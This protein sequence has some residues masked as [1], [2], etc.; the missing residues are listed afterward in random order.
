MADDIKTYKAERYNRRTI[1]RI[2]TDV[3]KDNPMKDYSFEDLAALLGIEDSGSK[4]MLQLVVSELESSERITK[5]S[6]GN[7]QAVIKTGV[8][9]GVLDLSRKGQAFVLPENSDIEIFIPS[10]NLHNGLHGDQVEVSLYA[11]S[12]HGKQEGEVVRIIKRARTTFVGTIEKN[13]NFAF[14]IANHKTMPYDIFIPLN[15]LMKA[16]AVIKRLQELRNGL[17]M[18]KILLVKL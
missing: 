13:K 18:Q 3:F 4:E 2:L 5:N 11:G 8:V 15:K 7:Y 12:K 1:T 14:L 17:K 6:F 9:I 10:E 16:Q